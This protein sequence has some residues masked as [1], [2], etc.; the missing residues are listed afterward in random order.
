MPQPILSSEIAIVLV[1]PNCEGAGCAM[2]FGEQPTVTGTVELT[3]D[4]GTAYHLVCVNTEDCGANYSP[5]YFVGTP[6]AIAHCRYCGLRAVWTAITPVEY[7]P[8]P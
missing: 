7:T 8:A 3:D 2:C 1:C 4:A 6:P 5:R